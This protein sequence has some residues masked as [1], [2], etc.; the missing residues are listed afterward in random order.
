MERATAEWTEG[1]LTC[2]THLCTHALT[3]DLLGLSLS[4]RSPQSKETHKQMITR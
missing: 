1:V 2:P 3:Q 4:L